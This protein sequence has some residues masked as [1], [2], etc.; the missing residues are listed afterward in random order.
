[1]WRDHK[2]VVLGDICEKLKSHIVSDYSPVFIQHFE[3][4]SALSTFGFDRAV[5][6]SA[7]ESAS[8][9]K[10]EF[11]V[12]ALAEIF[13][14]F[15]V[16]PSE[17]LAQHCSATVAAN[18]QTDVPDSA[19]SLIRGLSTGSSFDHAIP[20]LVVYASQVALAIYCEGNGGALV[21]V[22]LKTEAVG[23]LGR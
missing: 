21:V 5:V 4:D 2:D 19:E 15:E 7:V 3:I 18:C 23:S 11:L 14:E 16:R 8:L 22:F 6:A 13:E 17:F 10:T 9:S 1:M 12:H 20:K